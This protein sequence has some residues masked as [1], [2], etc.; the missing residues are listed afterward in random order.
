[1]IVLSN[2]SIADLEKTE[3]FYGAENAIDKILQVISRAKNRIDICN[4]YKLPIVVIDSYKDTLL[5]ASNRGNNVRYI[6]EINKENLHYC[7]EL[8]NI[9]SELRHLNGVKGNFVISETECLSATTAILEEAEVVLQ[10]IY[11][12]AKGVVEAQRYTFDIFW[13]KAISAQYRIKE[14]EE[15]VQYGGTKIIDSYEEVFNH[16]RYVIDSAAER[17]VC[18]SIGALQIIYNNF[19]ELYEKLL[20]RH[21]QTLKGR[22][23][24]IITYINRDSIRI[25]KEFLKI[26]CQ[27]R[28]V[29]NL[30]IISFA[31]D[32]R[33]VYA[34]IEKMEGG[35][36]I[37]SML[38]SD[39][40]SYIY[41]FSSFFEELWKD[42][43][44]A[45]DRIIDIENGVEDSIPEEV[46]SQ[47]SIIG[48]NMKRYLDKVLKEV[49]ATKK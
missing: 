3:I 46:E 6:T 26:G 36:L 11:S 28:H 17:S 29:Q 40:Q 16:M 21:R 15:G 10:V 41:H 20:Q 30:P 39:E 44:D 19:F 45:N 48:A 23:V 27:I 18:G 47:S 42:A 8:T 4:D 37:Q 5:R 12:N 25:I 9:V 31:F 7:K 22:G 38:T 34:T 33:F 24:R 43:L 2:I 1:M 35:K 14:I 32:D 13:N 49:A